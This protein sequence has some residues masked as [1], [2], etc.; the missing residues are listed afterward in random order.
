MSFCPTLVLG[1]NKV[2]R[3]KTL[4]IFLF[5][6]ISNLYGGEVVPDHSYRV[7]NGS[8]ETTSG[9]ILRPGEFIKVTRTHQGWAYAFQRLDRYLRPT[10]SLLYASQP[11]VE[12]AVVD[13]SIEE[14]IRMVQGAG[15]IVEESVSP[16]VP[17]PPASDGVIDDTI[18]ALIL[19][20][21]VE[22]QT[23]TGAVARSLRPVPRPTPTPA[24]TVAP[25]SEE[26]FAPLTS[27]RPVMRPP[28]LGA[29][30]LSSFIFKSPAEAD[31]YFACYKNSRDLH[32]DYETRYRTS[33]RRMARAY[34]QQ[35]GG[36]VPQDDVTTLMSCLIFRESAQW[37]GGSSSTGALGLGQFTETAREKVRNILSYNPGRT[38]SFDDRAAEQRAENTAG[39]ITNNTLRRN[40]SLIEAERENHDRKVALQELWSSIPMTDRPS[41]SEI[42]SSFVG[43][44]D[45]H[46][47]V[48]A[49]SALVLRNCQIRMEQD[50]IEMDPRTSLLACAGAYNMGVGGFQDNAIVRNGAQSLDGWINNLKNSGDSQ[51]AETRNHLVS[52]NRCI[53]DGENFPPCGTQANY[54]TALRMANPCTHGADPRCVG[55]CQ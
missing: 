3:V 45:N 36:S 18:A 53:S 44:N 32:L 38:R 16:R 50:N 22:E 30:D 20:S 24:A 1:H 17:C 39:R 40:L 35:T 25:N 4:C 47:A 28:N 51:S 10:G 52:V 54:C 2:V 12:R 55:E 49:M 48:I 37:R 14:I 42:N 26:S 21:V 31:S 19:E 34:G 7:S 29:S 5:L 33:I 11:W 23:Q 27:P 9:D 46:E 13:L 6:Q 43:N 15:D 41:A 8:I